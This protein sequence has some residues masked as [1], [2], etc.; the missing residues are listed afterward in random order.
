MNY[1]SNTLQGRSFPKAALLIYVF[2]HEPPS[3]CSSEAGQVL[4]VSLSVKSET[5]GLLT[6]AQFFGREKV[7][8]S[9]ELIAIS[10]RTSLLGNEIY[11]LSV[12]CRI[13]LPVESLNVG[14]GGGGGIFEA[15]TE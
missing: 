1:S 7:Y 6:S 2:E 11:S 10:Q 14:V 13:Q 3:C 12:Y 5:C 9:D 8:T 15:Y 4:L